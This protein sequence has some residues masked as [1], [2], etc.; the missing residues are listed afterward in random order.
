MTDLQ[1]CHGC[2]W[3]QPLQIYL[4]S[5]IIEYAKSNQGEWKINLIC[6]SYEPYTKRSSPAKVTRPAKSRSLP[7]LLIEVEPRAVRQ[8]NEPR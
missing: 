5:T 3:L 8:D 1:E 7:L 4:L 2:S 6:A